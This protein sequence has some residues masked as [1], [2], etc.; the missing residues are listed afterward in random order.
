MYRKWCPT[1]QELKQ[2]FGD[3]VSKK[4]KALKS[5]DDFKTIECIHVVIESENYDGSV[6][7][8]FVSF[9][10]EVEN[11]H[12]I[13]EVGRREFGYVVPRWQTE[14]GSQ[15]AYSPATIIAL[16]DARLMQQMTLILLEA[17]EKATN[18]PM[19]ANSE[20]IRSDIDL[21]GGGITWVD[22]HDGNLNEVLHQLN[23][24]AKGIPLGMEM[25]DG[26]RA[27]LIESF[28]INKLSLP[29]IGSG[30]TA[31]EVRQRIEEYIRQALPIF[32]P[33][34]ASYNGGLCDMTA[35]IL[36]NNGAFGSVQD[37]PASVRG[38]ELT[39]KYESPLHDAIEREKLERFREM[40]IVTTESMQVDPMLVH[41]IDIQEAYRDAISSSGIPSKWL[42]DT[43]VV[44]KIIEQAVQAQE[45]QAQAQAAQQAAQIGQ[46]VGAASMAL[47][48]A[49][50]S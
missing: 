20:I 24:D 8:P 37:M 6:K 36:I 28:F 15:Y 34:E 42:K 30:M 4:V 48:E 32:E 10:V 39:F 13:E 19:L 49:G 23:V 27:S 9:V 40:L 25:S 35:E 47:D 41:N 43:E 16:P 14:S 12:V 3:K 5:S 18:P 29:P 33:M 44:E 21:S 11:E 22:N 38:K 2:I 26:V 45:M 1:A 50:L 31:T 17:G 7:Q 46:D